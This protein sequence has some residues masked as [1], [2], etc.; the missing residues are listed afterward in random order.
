MLPL[1]TAAPMGCIRFEG[2][3]DMAPGAAADPRVYASEKNTHAA[4]VASAMGADY[5]PPEHGTVERRLLCEARAFSAP[6]RVPPPVA[7][8]AGLEPPAR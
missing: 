2:L 5:A 4:N 6:F 7:P 3:P 8:G 1:A